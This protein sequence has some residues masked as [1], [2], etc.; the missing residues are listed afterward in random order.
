MFTPTGELHFDSRIHG[1]NLKGE[2]C[3]LSAGGCDILLNMNW[4]P[5]CSG[6]CINPEVVVEFNF[7]SSR[8]RILDLSKFN[9]EVEI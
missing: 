8:A 6:G 9:F 2:R 3:N 5:T 4:R 7:S 1:L